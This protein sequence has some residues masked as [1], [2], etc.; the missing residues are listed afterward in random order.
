VII[1]FILGV[2]TNYTINIKW[3]FSERRIKRLSYEFTGYLVIVFSGLIF[4]IGIIWFLTE[5]INI[6]YGVSKLISAAIVFWWNFL[7]KKHVL[8]SRS[9]S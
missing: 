4:N 1:A 7:M 2:I 6:F 8:F 5:K 3:V 9:E